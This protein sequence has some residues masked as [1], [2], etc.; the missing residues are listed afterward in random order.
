MKSASIMP[1]MEICPDRLSSLTRGFYVPLI[2][3]NVTTDI[4]LE[5]IVI[6]KEPTKIYNKKAKK[7][8]ITCKEKQIQ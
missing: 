6:N 7:D 8:D 5:Y 4:R 3:I 1:Y 2:A